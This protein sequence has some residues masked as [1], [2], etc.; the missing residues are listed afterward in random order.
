ML[1]LDDNFVESSFEI[2][3]QINSEG[4]GKVILRSEVEC[5][6]ENSDMADDTL[7]TTSKRK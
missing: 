3:A 5:A 6:Q 1:E 4:T 2:S 7:K